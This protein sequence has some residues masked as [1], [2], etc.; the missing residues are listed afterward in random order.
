M[1]FVFLTNWAYL[2][3]HIA[4]TWDFVVTNVV[5]IC[6]SNIKKGERDNMPWYLMVN[7]LLFNVQNSIGL[8]VTL[9]YYIVLDADATP[10]SINKHAMNSVFIFINFFL[11]A[12]PVRLLHFYQ[13]IVFVALYG[14]FTLIYQFTT[15][16][17]IYPI[18]DW[19]VP[20]PTVLWALGLGLVGVPLAHL[21]FYGL[22]HL[23]TLVYSRRCSGIISDD[24][25]PDKNNA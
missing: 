20:W 19:S 7:W 14:G 25:V 13:P 18:L 8:L 11:C 22:Y 2:T 1:W 23:R 5:Q 3:L 15:G 21:C 4:S 12:K 10:S 16:Y 17:I 24:D 9:V 6:Q